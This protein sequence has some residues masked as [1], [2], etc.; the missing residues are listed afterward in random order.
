VDRDIRERARRALLRGGNV[1]SYVTVNVTV[2][3]FP[4][5]SVAIMVNAFSPA[6]NRM[7]STLQS[8]VPLAIPL[9]SRS[10]TQ[11]TRTTFVPSSDAVPLSRS[12]LLD[13]R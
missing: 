12:E 1:G 13:E 6:N 9:R 4:A 2:E 3:F 5:A 10:P 11:T 8:V 7:A